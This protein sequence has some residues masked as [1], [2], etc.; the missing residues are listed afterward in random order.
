LDSVFFAYDFGYWRQVA[1]NQ[2]I[3]NPTD[4]MDREAIQVLLRYCGTEGNGAFHAPKS[5]YEVFAALCCARP[6]LSG[7][8]LIKRYEYLLKVCF[9]MDLSLS[10]ELCDEIWQSISEMCAETPLTR[11]ECVLRLN[12][13]RPIRCLLSP[14][15]TLSELPDACIPVLAANEW[16]GTKRKTWE[17]WKQEMNTAFDV[18]AARG[19]HSAYLVLPREYQN[20]NPNRYSVERALN[21]DEENGNVLL[22][23]TLRML[24][25]ACT[26]REWTLLLRFECAE[27]D[28]RRLLENAERTV[29][30]PTIV[31]TTGEPRVRDSLLSFSAQSKAR[32]LLCGIALSDYPSDVELEYAIASYAARYPYGRLA[33]FSNCDLL[34]L[35]YEQ[36]RFLRL[37]IH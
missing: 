27:S 3:S 34:M 10:K 11:L 36:K 6:L 25:E 4:L 14:Y 15:E 5:D 8:P 7:H 31:W 20:H 24:C 9:G 35:S 12:E 2:R 18:F 23:Q 30:L 13:A 22:A 21:G 32:N 29:G 16:C 19:C 17:D 33:V 28:A 26:E 37:S 1:W